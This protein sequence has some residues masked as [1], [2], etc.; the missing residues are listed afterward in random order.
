MN[1]QE[2]VREKRRRQRGWIDALATQCL[3]RV[4]R[5][6]VIPRDEIVGDIKF[7]MLSAFSLGVGIGMVAAGLAIAAIW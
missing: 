4:P 1:V 2:V 7:V 6:V 5:Y 3:A